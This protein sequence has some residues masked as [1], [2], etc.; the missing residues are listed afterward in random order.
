LPITIRPPGRQIRTI[1][2]ATSNGFGATIAPKSH[3]EVETFVIQLVKVGRITFLKSTVGQSLIACAPV[4]GLDEISG[5][6]YAQHFRAP[7]APPA[8][9]SF[10]RRI[11]ES[12]TFSPRVMAI[13]AT[14]SS[15]LSRILS[16]MRVKSPFFPKRLIGTSLPEMDI[17]CA[18]EVRCCP[19]SEGMWTKR[20][21][22][23]LIP[24]DSVATGSPQI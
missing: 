5:D 4:A 17:S 12:N 24:A 13:L 16:A 3:D 7:G 20:Q 19:L 1:S 14:S 21:H 23:L 15:P 11:R 10:H 8:E 9:L 2:L 6:V 22:D 18:A